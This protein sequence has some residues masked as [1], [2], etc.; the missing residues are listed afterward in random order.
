MQKRTEK[1]LMSNELDWTI[2]CIQCNKHGVT[3]PERDDNFRFCIY[4]GNSQERRL[5]IEGELLRR[6]NVTHN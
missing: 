3:L 1:I 2:R 4:C 5:P 6:P